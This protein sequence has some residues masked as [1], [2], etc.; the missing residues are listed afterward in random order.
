[1]QNPQLCFIW[2]TG[3]WN[4]GKKFKKGILEGPLEDLGSQGLKFRVLLWFR[5]NQFLPELFR[6]WALTG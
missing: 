4:F 2:G 5:G 3:R 6:P 1:M